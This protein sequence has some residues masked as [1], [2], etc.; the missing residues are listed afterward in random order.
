MTDNAKKYPN[1]QSADLE[2]CAPNPDALG[3]P[4][5]IAAGTDIEIADTVLSDLAQRYGS[6]IISCDGQF[7]AYRGTHW[8]SIAP[9]ELKN[10]VYGYDKTKL[11]RDNVVKLNTARTGSILTIMGVRAEEPG[12]FSEAPKGINCQSGFIEFDVSGIPHINAGVKLYHIPGLFC[13]GFPA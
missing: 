2:N 1:P 4:P 6:R 8:C 12:F 9:K 3:V 11:T 10:A 7:Y 13:R 5:S